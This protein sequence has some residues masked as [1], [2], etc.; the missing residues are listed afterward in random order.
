MTTYEIKI[1]GKTIATTQSVTVTD[2][3][4][5]VQSDDF[6]DIKQG[7]CPEC[8]LFGCSTERKEGITLYRCINCG[9]FGAA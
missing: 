9:V 2:G 7:E 3:E 8:G 5:N 4:I 6:P 1:N